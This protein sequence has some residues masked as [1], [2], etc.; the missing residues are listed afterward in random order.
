M[1]SC[2]VVVDS[3]T[4]VELAPGSNTTYKYVKKDLRSRKKKFEFVQINSSINQN[5]TLATP[6]SSFHNLHD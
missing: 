3:V 5:V 1:I 6:T 2:I 4:L